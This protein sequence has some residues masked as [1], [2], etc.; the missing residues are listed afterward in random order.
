ME[1][2]R[3]LDNLRANAWQLVTIGAFAAVLFAFLV[4]DLARTEPD[5]GDPCE[6][7]A[8]E[9][10]VLKIGLW[11]KSQ[12]AREFFRP[13]VD[14]LKDAL[15]GVYTV[16]TEDLAG[17][18]DLCAKLSRGEIHVAGELSPVEYL[19]V[20]SSCRVEPFLGI[21][22]NGSPY[23]HSIL[24]VAR[25]REFK[26]TKFKDALGVNYLQAI[27]DIVERYPTMKIARLHEDSGSASG[28]WYPRSFLIHNQMKTQGYPLF[29][30]EEIIKRVLGRDTNNEYIAGFVADYILNAM[31]PADCK[32][33]EE[34]DAN[35][36][37]GCKPEKEADPERR[38]DP[39]EF[40]CPVQVD[41]SDP[42]LN[43]LFVMTK[44][45][46]TQAV[47]KVPCLRGLWKTLRPIKLKPGSEITDWR[48]GVEHDLRLVERHYE[49]VKYSHI[50]EDE[51]AR[52]LAV[53]LAGMVIL[54]SALATVYLRR[55]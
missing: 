5:D 27:S 15:G 23:Y 25:D 16:E 45:K 29:E 49:K 44:D 39:K 43:G 1:T 32:S 40:H 53:V 37:A 8:G 52:T 9:H 11:K 14:R 17:T 35:T 41:K 20:K 31:T 2:G 38:L 12:P 36:P 30:E 26:L 19:K 34:V 24:F 13:L 28:Y 47:L 55:L 10:V 18:G 7:I 46:R 54:M 6:A 33:Q 50:D 21:E 4:S 48:A 3:L 51:R 42:I 22:Y